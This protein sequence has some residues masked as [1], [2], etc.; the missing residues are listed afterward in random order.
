MLP[1]RHPERRFLEQVD[2]RDTNSNL[3][4]LLC[5]P[6]KGER[7]AEEEGKLG[8]VPCSLHFSNIN[9]GRAAAGK[10]SCTQSTTTQ[11]GSLHALWRHDRIAMATFS[12]LTSLGDH[13]E[14]DDGR[15]QATG[16]MKV[17][18]NQLLVLVVV[19]GE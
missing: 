1:A 2:Q 13:V 10:N 9:T 3:G 6:K 12:N 17:S 14:K 4:F 8:I 5:F 16:P 19:V 11:E 15:L 7:E 18:E